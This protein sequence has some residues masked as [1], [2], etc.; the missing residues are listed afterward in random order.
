MK[1]KKYLGRAFIYLMLALIYLPI[2]VLI[3]Y[4]FTATKTIGGEWSGFTFSLYAQVFSDSEMMGA[5]GNSLIVALTSSLLATVIGT[6]AAVGIYYTRTKWYK[7]LLNVTSQVTMVNA[8]IVTGVSFMM[9]FL[10]FGMIPK[11]YLT[12]I[13]SHTMITVPYV[14]MN[15]MPRLS[16]LNPNLYEA[17]LDLG[18][19]PVRT[20]LTVLLPQLIP[21]MI[22]GFAL[23]FTLSLDDFVVTKFVNGDVS[24]ISTYLYNKIAKKGVMPELRALSTLIFVAILAVL[25]A[26]NVSSYRRRKKL[27]KM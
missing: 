5:V 9:L 17:G 21:S 13:I 7:M 11:G 16:Q 23:A 6:L 2:L 1:T 25:I 15:V 19:G 10:V 24:T 27:A 20:F 8:D 4:S 3:V 12:L 22:S 26:V 18:A 14:I